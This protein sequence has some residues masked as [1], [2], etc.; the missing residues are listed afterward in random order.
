LRTLTRRA[1][2]EGSMPVAVLTET[3]IDRPRD[4]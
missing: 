2:E 1:E 3:A 4:Q